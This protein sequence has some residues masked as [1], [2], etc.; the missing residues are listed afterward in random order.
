LSLGIYRTVKTD[1]LSPVTGSPDLVRPE[2]LMPEALKKSC[3]SDVLSK[4]FLKKLNSLRV[5]KSVPPFS[6]CIL[7]VMVQGLIPE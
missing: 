2:A 6:L 7:E 5:K 3:L 1:L 4:R